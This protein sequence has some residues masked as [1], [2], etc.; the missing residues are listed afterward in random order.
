MKTKLF[1]LFALFF[2]VS[3][4]AQDIWFL[5]TSFK[6]KLLSS[7][8]TNNIAQD[9]NGNFV[10]VDSN[11][12]NEIQISE[13]ENISMLNLNDETGYGSLSGINEISYFKNIQVLKCE[14]N[15]S[16]STLNLSN[17]PLLREIYASK[18]KV[19]YLTLVNL[20]SLKII[21]I[22]ASGYSGNFAVKDL[23]SL[24]KIKLNDNFYLNNIS[25]QNL[26]MLNSIDISY[27]NIQSLNISDFP[28]LKEIISNNS[29]ISN[30]TLNNLPQ[31]LKVNFNINKIADFNCKGCDNLQEIR[32]SYNN[33]TSI[34]VSNNL[35]L[36]YLN[37]SNNLLTDINLLKN[38]KLQELICQFN[39]LKSLDLSLTGVV[40]VEAYVNALEFINIK[41]GV[42][43]KLNASVGNLKYICCDESEINTINYTCE[44][45]TPP[46]INSYCS[47]E[48][49]G[50]YNNI[51]GNVKLDINNNGC[52][53]TDANFSK[54]KIK[55]TKDGQDV[56]TTI[57]DLQGNYELFT[58]AGNFVLTPVLENLD[59]YTVTPS[60]ATINFPNTNKN[61]FTQNFCVVP[62]GTHNDLEVQFVPISQARPG[63]DATYRF[64][65]FNKGNT[66]LSGN[67][68][69]DY[70]GNKVS[71]VNSELPP[72]TNVNSNLVWNFTDLKPFEQK[73]F[74]ITF[75][76]N[77]PSHPTDPLIAGDKLTFTAK[78]F[79]INNDE[80][81][82]DNNLVLHQTVVNSVDPNDKTC[83]EGDII[84]PDLVGNDV[85]YL[86]RFENVG[87]A[88][89][90]NVV[91]KD[92]IDTTKFDVESLQPIKSSHPYRMTI[93]EGNKVEFFFE[94][95]QLPFDDANNDGYILFKIKTK[96]T[97]V[98][99]NTFSNKADIYFDYNFPIATNEAITTVQNNLS[100]QEFSKSEISV[101]PNPVK[102]ILTFKTKEKVKKVEIYDVNGRLIKVEL[103]IS[104][105][106][107]NVSSLKTG[108]YVIKVI[109]DKKYYQTKFIKQ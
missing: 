105:N 14:N 17:L 95:I 45:C 85:H 50:S 107:M 11:K 93:T 20:P 99:G 88:N 66:T 44:A 6:D 55:I 52:E 70:Q 58:D 18:S 80:T 77:P 36:K 57:S 56:G 29:N 90:V 15:Y 82:K 79:P 2:F 98:V 21:D 101:Y 16:L 96:P 27:G 7:S 19:R 3:L 51:L 87:T 42:N 47:F 39:K 43:T 60:S 30:V 84:T 10:A 33:L 1:F 62:N 53:T 68:N 69:L 83:L 32:I 102:D 31:L 97:L 5:N 67:V 81:P 35:Q 108:T 86:I 41:N 94:N 106:Q 92:M 75:K 22:S 24:E 109:S 64:V 65:Y 104:N 76:L 54:L 91:V 103:G 74:I 48:P 34:D 4:E 59:Y 13:A 46:S 9:I 89:A 49:G 38:S 78:I 40:L 25:I 73:S 37:I 100:T 26:P 23:P 12:D 8:P 71:F 28:N 61:T 63:F 72:D